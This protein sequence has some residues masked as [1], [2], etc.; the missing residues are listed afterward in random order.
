[1]R[2]SD[3]KIFN[4]ELVVTEDDLDEMDHVNNLRYLKWCLKAA[5]AHSADVGW[6][7]KRYRESGRGF[8]VRSHK[9]KY[10]IPA[11]LNDEVIVKTWIDNME[12]VSSDRRYTVI[13]ASDG[14]RL[15]EAETTWVYVDL[16]TLELSKIP[17]EI[18]LAFQR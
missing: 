5:V 17:D 18:R 4:H 3:A 9:I 11:V 14:K 2:S 7:S 16:A 15:A 1:M 12:R 8:I 10:R 13:R 6:N